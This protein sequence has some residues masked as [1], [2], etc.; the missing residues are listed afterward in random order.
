MPIKSKMSVLSSV[1]SVMFVITT[2]AFADY[3]ENFNITGNWFKISGDGGMYD[4]NKKG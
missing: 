2:L 3:T 1:L 4:W